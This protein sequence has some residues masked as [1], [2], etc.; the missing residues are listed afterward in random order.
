MWQHGDIAIVINPFS[1]YLFWAKFEFATFQKHIMDFY[2]AWKDGKKIMPL[3]STYKY[4][5]N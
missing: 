3:L 1:T 4:K 5:R 2:V